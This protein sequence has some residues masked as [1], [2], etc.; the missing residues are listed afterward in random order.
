[1]PVLRCQHQGRAPILVFASIPLPLSGGLDAIGVA[2]FRR[3]SQ[4]SGGRRPGMQRQKDQNRAQ[5]HR[6]NLAKT[7]EPGPHADF[8]L[9]AGIM[10]H[11]GERC[12]SGDDRSRPP[13][14]ENGHTLRRRG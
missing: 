10:R 3:G 5:H 6:P 9:A 1:V 12:L 4:T 7:G 13:G 14:F 11:E 2:L 8:F